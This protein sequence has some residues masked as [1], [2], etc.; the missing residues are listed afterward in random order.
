M[1]TDFSS[2]FAGHVDMDDIGYGGTPVNDRTFSD[3]HLA[4]G[5]EK[6]EAIVLLM[7]RMG[8]DSFWMAEHHFQPEGYEVIPNLLL[9]QVHLA[10]LTKN[11]K[12]GCGFNIA[13]MWH[14]LRLA[15]DYA[16]ADI[17]TGG[18]VIFGI[19]RGYHTREVETF[20]SPLIDQVAARDLFEEQVEIIFK[21]FNERSFSHH[22]KNY[23]IPPRNVAYRGYELEEITLVPRPRNL[24]VETWQPIQGGTTRA[25]DFMAKHGIRGQIGGGVAEGGAMDSVIEDY[26]AALARAGRETELGEDLAVGFHCHLAPSREQGIKKAAGY[27]EENLK[28]FGPLRLT[29]RLSDQQISDIG[30]RKLAP[31]AGLPALEEAVGGGAYLCGPPDQVIEQLKA[32]EKRYPGLSRINVSQPVGTPQSVILEQLQWFAEEV[33]PAFKPK[34]EAAV[35]AD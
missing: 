22:G 33:M 9:F 11:I 31:K 32:V 1:I 15:E 20:G 12:F 21:A 30:D 35:P 3:D 29:R 10:H 13:P 4:T 23:D 18:R 2:L 17:L 24:P 19:G 34:V 7:D 5:F 26:R 16:Q 6:A 27:F 14:P 8:Y 28:M 25:L